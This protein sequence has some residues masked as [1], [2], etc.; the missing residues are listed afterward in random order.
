MK[1]L[2]TS[3]IT[4]ILIITT[5]NAL[6]DDPTLIKK[7]EP[8]PYNG[9]LF[10]IP[11]ATELHKDIVERDALKLTNE[12][13]QK[14][15]SITQENYSIEQKKTSILDNRNDELAKRLQ[16]SNHTSDGE[17][18][19]WMGVGIVVTGVAIYGVSQLRK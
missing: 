14:S 2:K 9:L 18:L 1:T 11:K 3:L 19:L 5:T 13:L 6:A 10:S 4:L 15:L 7:N 8:A 12:S 16:E 17:K